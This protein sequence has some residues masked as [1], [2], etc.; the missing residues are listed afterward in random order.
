MDRNLQIP[1]GRRLA[2]V[3]VILGLV[4]VSLAAVSPILHQ[5]QQDGPRRAHD[6]HAGCGHVHHAHPAPESSGDPAGSGGLP[7]QH[8][9]EASCGFC[10]LL[11]GAPAPMSVDLPP[12]GRPTR[13]AWINGLSSTPVYRNYPADRSGR[14]PPV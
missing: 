3:L 14:G 6:A 13:I 2:A 1:L 10:V 11:M 7:A 12:I 4:L 5:H 8:H 9:D